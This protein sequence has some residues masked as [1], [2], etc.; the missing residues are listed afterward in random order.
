MKVVADLGL[1]SNVL[2]VPAP[3][4]PKKKSFVAPPSTT[5][6]KFMALKESSSVGTIWW[7][8]GAT[9]FNAPDV[10]NPALAR[11]EERKEEAQRKV[12]KA[13]DD[14]SSLKA[15]AK[16]TEK[17]RTSEGLTF[18]DLSADDAKLLVSFVFSARKAKGKTEHMKK[19]ATALAFL[20]TLAPG[21]MQELLTRTE[22]GVAA[23]PAL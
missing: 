16:D 15:L 6:Q 9:A 12:E 8:V 11:L 1:N 18:D 10:I 19:K 7:A 17:R 20:Q 4:K 23:V 5:E 22:P 13:A 21:E 3:P 2:I 14:W